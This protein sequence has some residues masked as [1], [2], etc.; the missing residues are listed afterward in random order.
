[1]KHGPLRVREKE[2]EKGGGNGGE[3]S[4][5]ARVASDVLVETSEARE[6]EERK[7]RKRD[8]RRRVTWR[9]K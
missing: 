4:H 5:V 6:K 8:C 1:M 3:R 7:R 9:R 2:D